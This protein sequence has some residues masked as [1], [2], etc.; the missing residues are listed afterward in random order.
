[1]EIKRQWNRSRYHVAGAVVAV[2]GAVVSYIPGF[3]TLGASIFLSAMSIINYDPSQPQS[4]SNQISFSASYSYSTSWGQ[5]SGLTANQQ[6]VIQRGM[7]LDSYQY[8]YSGCDPDDF[9]CEAIVYPDTSIQVGDKFS[10]SQLVTLQS[11]LDDLRKQIAKAIK[12]L[13]T[14]LQHF[15]DWYGTR[16]SSTRTALG[17][18]LLKLQVDMDSFTLDRFITAFSPKSNRFYAQAADKKIY[19]SQRFWVMSDMSSTA[20]MGRLAH[21]S[22]H[23]IWTD[24]VF[25]YYSSKNNISARA[26]ISNNNRIQA[27]NNADN[28]RYWI[29]G[30]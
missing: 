26:Q 12:S 9:E 16:S 29:Q 20:V 8:L 28:F 22:S 27:F 21:E 30:I 4:M 24:D 25:G 5:G 10:I 6:G 14:N 11:G 1:L 2:V 7:L 15:E 18:N 13:N 19:I 3:Q 23:F 17:D